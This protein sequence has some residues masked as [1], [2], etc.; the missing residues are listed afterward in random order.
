MYPIQEQGDRTVGMHIDA[1]VAE[2]ADI[3]NITY[4]FFLNVLFLSFYNKT[5]IWQCWC[6]YKW[7]YNKHSLIFRIFPI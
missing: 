4:F 1:T 6:C 7:Q 5:I 2:I 3:A